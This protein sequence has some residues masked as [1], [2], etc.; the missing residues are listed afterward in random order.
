MNI[1]ENVKSAFQ[2]K[3]IYL[4]ESTFKILEP[5]KKLENINFGIGIEAN[6][7]QDG[8]TEKLENALTIIL[9]IEERESFLLSVTMVGIFEIIKEIPFDKDEFLNI[10]APTII[11]P[12]IR[13]HVRTLSL[14][15]GISPILLPVINFVALAKEN[16]SE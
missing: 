7:F 12:Y 3:S 13:Q 16:Y 14:E 4:R 15:A 8:E 2:L 10:N 5:N 1:N 9:S 6:K 11:Y